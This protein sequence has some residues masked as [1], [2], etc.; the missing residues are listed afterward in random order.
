MAPRQLCAVLWLVLLAIGLLS[1]VYANLAPIVF[2]GS[3]ALMFVTVRLSRVTSR[4]VCTM[5]VAYRGAIAILLATA[6]LGVVLG[7]LPAARDT[8]KVLAILFGVVSLLSYRALVARGPSAAIAAVAIIL[9]L[10]FPFAFLALFG[11]HPRGGTPWTT[12]AT[13]RCLVATMLL[14]PI[15][16]SITLLSFTPRQSELPDARLLR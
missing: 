5:P 14:L 2:F 15:T 16:A 12:I 1:Y 6:L 4:E 8:S 11:C 10:W 7:L 3:F 9:V 13:M